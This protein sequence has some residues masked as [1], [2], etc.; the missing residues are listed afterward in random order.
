MFVKHKVAFNQAHA[1]FQLSAAAIRHMAK[2][3]HPMAK[4]S[5]DKRRK[6]FDDSKLLR[7]DPILIETIH[8]LGPKASGEGADIWIAE[9][10]TNR[11][12]IKSFSGKE[13]VKEIKDESDTSAILIK[14]EDFLP[15]PTELTNQ[16]PFDV[17]AK[18]NDQTT[19]DSSVKLYSLSDCSFFFKEGDD[20]DNVVIVPTTYWQEHQHPDSDF[21][22]KS[23][24][25]RVPKFLQIPVSED[26]GYIFEFPENKNHEDLKSQLL[27]LGMNFIEILEKASTEEDEVSLLDSEDY[28]ADN[29]KRSSYLDVEGDLETVIP[30][31]NT[32][33]SKLSTAKIKS[34]MTTWLSEEKVIDEVLKTYVWE[35]REAYSVSKLAVPFDLDPETASAEQLREAVKKAW[36]NGSNWIRDAKN[37]VKKDWV[38]YINGPSVYRPNEKI[39][40]I[41]D[42]AGNWNQE[43]VEKVYND[44]EMAESCVY[45]LFIPRH[46]FLASNF[47]LEIL[48]TPEDDEVIGWV[49]ICD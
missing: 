33:K 31:L 40:F 13:V 44:P 25:G 48:T 38:D 34:M 49:V 7:H 47:R 30:T 15:P 18:L 19:E 26:K 11:Y 16:I 42:F 24:K 43:L 1:V 27:K 2:L 23:F 3:G 41:Y 20:I 6:E 8:E 10:Y 21:N 9:I 35:G 39:S 5:L 12:K 36:S 32:G 37:M 28:D 46:R 17:I 14:D 4:A 45:R 22:A 29:L